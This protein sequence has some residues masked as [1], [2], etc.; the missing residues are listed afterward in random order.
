MF[1]DPIGSAKLVLG[2]VS[3]GL[4]TAAAA[5]AANPEV[6]AAAAPSLEKSVMV[7][8]FGILLAAGRS[9]LPSEK[10]VDNQ[11]QTVVDEVKYGHKGLTKKLEDFAYKFEYDREKS[12]E[13]REDLRGWM[14]RID[15]HNE[16]MV[17]RVS[18]I[19]DK[20]EK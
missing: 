1:H 15:E 6:A 7:L 20:L 3:V 8:A 4:T 12:S 13:F 9:Y 18:K 2:S 11:F 5:V 16:H 19:E 14:G 10:K 17:A